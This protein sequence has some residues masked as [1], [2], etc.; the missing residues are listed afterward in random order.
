MV[1]FAH[2]NYTIDINRLYRK[3]TEQFVEHFAQQGSVVYLFNV[4]FSVPHL[5]RIVGSEHKLNWQ[6]CE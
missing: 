6:H 1:T 5:S 3:Y 2:R 4:P